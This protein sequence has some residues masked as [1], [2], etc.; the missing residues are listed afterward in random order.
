M[1]ELVEACEEGRDEEREEGREEGRDDV[2]DGESIFLAASKASSGVSPARTSGKLPE[3]LA[4]RMRLSVE[5]D[6]LVPMQ[7]LL[8]PL[9]LLAMSS[10]CDTSFTSWLSCSARRSDGPLASTGANAV[11][12][13]LRSA[14][15]CSTL[16][17]CTLCGKEGPPA[18]IAA[19]RPPTAP[20][21]PSP[22]APATVASG[23]STPCC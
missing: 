9:L 8:L 20:S 16:A 7:Q 6:D 1:A 3:L 4:L 15:C 5:M 17:S 21:V 18:A 10:T 13:R 12:R 19:G 2:R 22:L 23:L 11:W 14:C